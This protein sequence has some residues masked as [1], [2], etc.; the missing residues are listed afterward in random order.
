VIPAR[1][2]AALLIGSLAA[3][4][5]LADRP[6]PRVA[7]AGPAPSDPPPARTRAQGRALLLAPPRAP[8]LQA[9][10]LPQ[11]VPMAP[12]ELND[13]KPLDRWWFWATAGG[14][15]VATAALFLVATSGHD[16][17]PTRLGNMEAFR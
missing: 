16:R 5:A 4:P 17:P 12:G 9:V 11:P 6:A 13:P 10:P 15:V 3:S 8:R 2:L 7:S 14:L 1:C